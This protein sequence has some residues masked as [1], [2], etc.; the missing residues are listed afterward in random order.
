MVKDHD[1]K[2]WILRDDLFW[3][4]MQKIKASLNHVT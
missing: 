4:S 2:V 3:L 1:P